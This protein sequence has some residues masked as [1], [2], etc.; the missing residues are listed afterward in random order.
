M[1]EYDSCICTTSSRST[2]ATKTAILRWFLIFGSLDSFEMTAHSVY[3]WI[4]C[5]VWESN[6]SSCGDV[7]ALWFEVLH[8]RVCLIGGH[9]RLLHPTHSFSG[10][11]NFVLWKIVEYE[12]HCF[13]LLDRN[14]AALELRRCQLYLWFR[15]PTSASQEWRTRGSPPR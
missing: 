10:G 14:G 11:E 9:H 6:H 13:S 3:T 1:Y 7:L 15:C 12:Q 5:K 4:E 8:S 2:T